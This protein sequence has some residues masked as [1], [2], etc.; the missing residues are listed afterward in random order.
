MTETICPECN[1]EGVVDQGTED[2]RRCPTCNGSG[3]VPDDGQGSEE[4][5]N[6]HPERGD[7]GEPDRLISYSSRS[8]PARVAP[9]RLF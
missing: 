6:T 2:E 4:V 7:D 8:M 9:H 3:I 5:W 1:G